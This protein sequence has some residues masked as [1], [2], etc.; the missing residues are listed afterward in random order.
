M[1]G[2]GVSIS[3][4][5][6]IK[7]VGYLREAYVINDTP[8][9][10]YKAKRQ[11]N[12]FYKIYNEDVAFNS[13]RQTNNRYDLSH[14]LENIVLNELYFKGYEVFVYNNKGRE[15]D[16]LAVKNGKKYL[17]QVS[18]SIEDEK[19]YEREFSAFSHVDNSIKKI[20]ITTDDIDYSTSTV[21]HI[22][23]KDFL[24]MEELD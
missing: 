19:T 14:N 22:K 4:P 24:M 11:L 15:I 5:T 9:F 18:Y 2:Q 17:V 3:V 12:Y 23:L 20:I 1:K 13:I 10:S 6:I 7:Y 21:Q 8:L 16:F